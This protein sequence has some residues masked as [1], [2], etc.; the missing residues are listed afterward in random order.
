MRKK[1]LMAM[2]GGVDSSV[3]AALLIEQGYEVVGVFMKNWDE[4]GITGERPIWGRFWELASL[5]GE[6]SLL[7]KNARTRI[8]DDL[9][10]YGK[11]EQTYSL[12]HADFAPENL[13][14]DG[15]HVYLQVVRNYRGQGRG[16]ESSMQQLYPVHV[17]AD[18]RSTGDN[19]DRR[20]FRKAFL[21]VYRVIVRA[22]A[23]ASFASP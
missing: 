1:I 13:M 19:H 21:L 2:S 23:S 9:I 18:V 20:A 15:S 3:S 5:S 16:P 7:L 22:R 4:E 14:V 11:S 12:I 17:Y 10:A 8:H 6:E